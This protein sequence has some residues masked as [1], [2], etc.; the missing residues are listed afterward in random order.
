MQDLCASIAVDMEDGPGAAEDEEEEEAGP[1]AGAVV[2]HEDKKYYPSADEV[3]GENVE[4]L[5]QE[6]DAQPLE[7]PIIAPI[8]QKK[9][10]TL[11]REPLK[12][13]FTYEFL[14]TLMANPELVRNVAVVGHLHHGKTTIMDML[15]E[16]VCSMQHHVLRMESHHTVPA[17]MHV[18]QGTDAHLLHS[19]H[20][21]AGANPCSFCLFACCAHALQT[22]RITP[23]C[24]TCRHTRSS[25]SGA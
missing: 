1:M 20:A 9:I 25:M 2:L 22:V 17:H 3:Y 21:G 7:V 11:E 12:A 14:A 19:T 13:R 24:H 16:Q 15:V 8:K 4:T 18:L 5:V 23:I 6:E 10:E